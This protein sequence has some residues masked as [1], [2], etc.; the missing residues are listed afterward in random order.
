MTQRQL[1]AKLKREHSF[2]GRIE[3]GERRLDLIEFWEYCR[4]CEAN[5]EEVVI[6]V[7]SRFLD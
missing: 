6:K 7:F 3:I 1:A 5:P 2:V 4:A